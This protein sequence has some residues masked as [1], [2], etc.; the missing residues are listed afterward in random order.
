MCNNM[1]TSM[2]LPPNLK[3]QNEFT[4]SHMYLASLAICLLPPQ[5]PTMSGF[6]LSPSYFLL[7]I[8]KTDV[9]HIYS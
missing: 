8:M 5:L 7:F 1:L 4:H 2:K 6:V 9:L 3:S